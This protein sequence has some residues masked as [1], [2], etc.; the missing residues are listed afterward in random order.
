MLREKTAANLSGAIR[1]RKNRENFLD[2]VPAT[3]VKADAS[4]VI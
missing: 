2:E 1:G 4:N 3:G